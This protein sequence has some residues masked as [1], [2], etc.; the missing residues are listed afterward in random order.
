MTDHIY[1]S[2][3][4]KIS[5]DS[6]RYWIPYVPDFRH[7]IWNKVTNGVTIELS[8]NEESKDGRGGRVYHVDMPYESFRIFGFLDDTG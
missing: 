3:Y 5:G 1:E 8:N 7:A 4:H 6:M 2:F